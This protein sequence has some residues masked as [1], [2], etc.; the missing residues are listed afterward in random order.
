MAAPRQQYY[1]IET[2]RKFYRVVDMVK[3]E[4]YA[5]LVKQE[6]EKK[7]K[8][9][10]RNIIPRACL[11]Q[12]SE[13]VIEDYFD[14]ETQTTKTRFRPEILVAEADSRGRLYLEKGQEELVRRILRVLRQ[15][16]GTVQLDESGLMLE[17]EQSEEAK[18]KNVGGRP[19]K[20]K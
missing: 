13:M 6:K 1:I 20:A 15:I 7:L 12:T 5:S 14:N 11:F 18:T 4:E 2:G 19:K 16:D 10:H 17:E 8:S 9:E 3:N